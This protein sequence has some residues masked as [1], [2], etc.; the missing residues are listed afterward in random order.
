VEVEKYQAEKAEYEYLIRG[1]K[2]DVNKLEE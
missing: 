1:L 2:G